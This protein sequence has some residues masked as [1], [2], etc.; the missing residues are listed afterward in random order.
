M[1]APWYK[2]LS[3]LSWVQRF[4]GS[5]LA[6]YVR[7]VHATSRPRRTDLAEAGSRPEDHLPAILTFWHGEHFMIAM[8]SR[9]EWRPHAMVSRSD[10]GTINA[11]ALEKLGVTAVRG[12]G[13]TKRGALGKGHAK[14][15]MTAFRVF[16]R[17]LA[18]GASVAMTAEVPKNYRQVSPGL[19]RL[20]RTTGRPIIPIAYVTHP[21]ITLPSWDHAALNL[22]FTR[23]AYGAHQPIYVDDSLPGDEDWC[24][25]VKARLNAITE[26]C[27]AACGRRPGDASRTA[28]EA[29]A[30]AAARGRGHE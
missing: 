15:G 17:L 18:E 22:P 9:P 11:I 6:G 29:P 7:L 28:Q 12:A 5:A 20:A 4:A 25:L 1:A 14:G 27:Y 19:V 13:E 16:T 3:R 26:H 24:A 21:R 10:D 2:R 30:S 23:A 8:A